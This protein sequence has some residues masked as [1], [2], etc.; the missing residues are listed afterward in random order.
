[1]AVREKEEDGGQKVRRTL[2]CQRVARAL[3]RR[4]MVATHV[5]A[6]VVSAMRFERACETASAAA[7]APWRHPPSLKKDKAV[8]KLQAFLE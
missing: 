4:G 1:M 8:A 2:G 3:R 5:F 7:G 6:G